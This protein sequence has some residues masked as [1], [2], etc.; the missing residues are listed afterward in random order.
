MFKL[1]NEKLS[2]NYE[3][4][5]IFFNAGEFPVFSAQDRK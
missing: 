1:L 2:Q 5:K 4:N 3:F